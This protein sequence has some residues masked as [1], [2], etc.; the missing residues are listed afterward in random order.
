MKLRWAKFGLINYCYCYYYYYY[1]YFDIRIAKSKYIYVWSFLLD[2][3]TL[4]VTFHTPQTLIL[5]EWPLHQGCAVI[6]LLLLCLCLLYLRLF[7]MN[8]EKEVEIGVLL[9]DD[10]CVFCIWE[11]H[12]SWTS[13][14]V[15]NAIS[16]QQ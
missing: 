8:I 16:F 1:Y 4:L 15:K 6:L 2:T 11:R 5:V 9:G 3:W 10:V 13:H 7:M 12:C 14:E